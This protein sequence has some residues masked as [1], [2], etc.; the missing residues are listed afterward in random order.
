[1]IG[2]AAMVKFYPGLLLP[3]MMFSYDTDEKPGWLG[4]LVS[5]ILSKPNI[6]MLA[7]FGAVVVAVIMAT[8]PKT[9]LKF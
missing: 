1:M 7:A 6:K 9:K 8:P 4:R 5:T 3:A 2:L